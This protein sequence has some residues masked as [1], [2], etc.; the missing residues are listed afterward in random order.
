MQSSET[1]VT[2]NYT[3]RLF[4]ESILTDAH[5]QRDPQKPHDRF[6]HVF[7]KQPSTVYHSRETSHWNEWQRRGR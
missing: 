1:S 6:L 5:T 7:Q 4:K 2:T 3:Y